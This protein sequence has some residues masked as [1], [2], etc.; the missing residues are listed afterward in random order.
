[1]VWAFIGVSRNRGLFV[2]HTHTGNPL[3]DSVAEHQATQDEAY[4]TYF[5]AMCYLAPAAIPSL[6]F[7]RRS[8]AK[9]F[10]LSFAFIAMYF[11]RKMVRLILLLSPAASVLGG[12]TIA[13]AL[14]LKSR[15]NREMC[16][17]GQVFMSG[18]SVSYG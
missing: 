13:G 9:Y 2:Q 17:L 7:W 8:E 18:A 5:D 6:I 16:A 12:I 3:V 15:E 14:C 11:S 4:A 10:L 1:M